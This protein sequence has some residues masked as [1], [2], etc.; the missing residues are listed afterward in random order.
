MFEFECPA[1]SAGCNVDVKLVSCE[2][3][4][5]QVPFYP[6]TF[7]LVVAVLSSAHEDGDTEKWKASAFWTY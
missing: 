1:G 3:P 6:S 2:T 5:V 7:C 4:L